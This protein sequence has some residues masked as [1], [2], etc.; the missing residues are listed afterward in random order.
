MKYPFRL[1]AWSCPAVEDFAIEFEKNRRGRGK[2]M[3]DGVYQTDVD[4]ENS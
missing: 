4:E 1:P 3:A 2:G